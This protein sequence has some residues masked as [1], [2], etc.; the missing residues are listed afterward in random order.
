MAYKK[1][2][3]KQ[4]EEMIDADIQGREI[5][6]PTVLDESIPEKEPLKQRQIRM[7]DTD[8]TWLQRHFLSKGLTI[9]AGLRMIVKEYMSKERI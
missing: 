1:P 9:S 5:G 4:F 7:S 6:K 3:N 2:E 8:W